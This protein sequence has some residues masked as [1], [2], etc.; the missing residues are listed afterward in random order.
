MLSI[1]IFELVLQWGT[2]PVQPALLT[3]ALTETRYL[4]FLSARLVKRYMR[5]RGASASKACPVSLR[6][7]FSFFSAGV[8]FRAR[9]LSSCACKSQPRNLGEAEAASSLLE[10]SRELTLGDY[11]THPHFKCVSLDSGALQNDCTIRTINIGIGRRS[12]LRYKQSW[13]PTL[14]SAAQPA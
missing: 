8:S 2:W 5:T 14:L 10:Q 13:A 11:G 1:A 7:F 6:S 3:S 12:V 9:F 4:C